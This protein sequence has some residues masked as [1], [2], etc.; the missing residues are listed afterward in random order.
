MKPPKTLDEMVSLMQSRGLEIA[1]PDDMRRILFDSNYYRLSGYFR[2]FQ[3]DP[4]HGDN[5]FKT[6]TTAEDFLAPY[7]LDTELRGLI[8]KGTARIELT[9]RSRFAYLVALDGGAYDYLSETSYQPARNGRGVELRARLIA[10]MHKWMDMSNEVCIRHYRSRNEPVPIW[11]AV[12]TMPFDTISRMIGLHSDTNA[13]RQLYKS[14]GLRTNIRTSAEIIHAMV[15]LRNMCSH[16]SRL[17]HREMVIV[18]PVTKDMRKRFPDLAYEGKSVEQALIA[19]LYL[20]DEINGNDG[21]SSGMLGFLD[22]HPE[23]AGGLRHPL[24]WE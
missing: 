11:A 14:L 10:N 15:Y 19:L 24:H 4:A 6:G 23:Y 3:N 5:D 12:E 18:P 22:A 17:W 1:H 13:L 8:L 20:V 9:V 21:Y 16:H 2:P 7:R